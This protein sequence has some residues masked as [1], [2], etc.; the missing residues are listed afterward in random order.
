LL[1]R[2]DPTGQDDETS[3]IRIAAS[4]MDFH[5]DAHAAGQSTI[6]PSFSV[7]VRVLPDWVELADE[8]LGRG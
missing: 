7:Y 4:G 1:P 3:D 6:T 2:F 8:A 5:I